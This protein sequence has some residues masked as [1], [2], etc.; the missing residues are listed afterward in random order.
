MGG[1]VGWLGRGAQGSKAFSQSMNLTKHHH[2]RAH[3]HAQTRACA[4]IHRHTA[5]ARAHTHTHTGSTSVSVLW[6]RSTELTLPCAE[7]CAMRS[8]RVQSAGTCAQ[9]WKKIIKFYSLH[10]FGRLILKWVQLVDKNF[11][12]ETK[13]VFRWTYPKDYPPVLIKLPKALDK[14][15]GWI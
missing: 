2:T 3:T 12:K 14:L 4:C 7:K 1:S 11:R 13:V 6:M 5:R 9:L 8:S 15:L 10:S